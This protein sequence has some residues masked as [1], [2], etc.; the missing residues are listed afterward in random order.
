MVRAIMG[1]CGVCTA[2]VGFFKRQVLRRALQARLGRMVGWLVATEAAILPNSPQR[3]AFPI[4]EQPLAQSSGL[5]N[6]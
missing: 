6:N 1:S 3:K 4:N 5:C 2:Y